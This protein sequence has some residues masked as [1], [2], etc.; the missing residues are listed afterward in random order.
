MNNVN[1]NS[2]DNNS[3]YTHLEQF[4]SEEEDFN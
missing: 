3:K 4:S 1:D 2:I